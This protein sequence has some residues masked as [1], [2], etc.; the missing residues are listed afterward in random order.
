[1]INPYQNLP[2][3]TSV[4]DLEQPEEELGEC[5]ECG[6]AVEIYTRLCMA[7]WLA[8]CGCEVES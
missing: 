4:L 2:P 8:E 5:R 6:K 1:M 7:C 3:G